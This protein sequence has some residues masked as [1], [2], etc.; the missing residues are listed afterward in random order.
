MA[1]TFVICTVP[2][3][4]INHAQ[5][6]YLKE[7]PIG[8]P[9]I[10]KSLHLRATRLLVS[11]EGCGSEEVSSKDSGRKFLSTFKAEVDRL[12]KNKRGGSYK[13]KA[14][15]WERDNSLVSR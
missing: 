2:K 4:L 11:P 6:K 7:L 5:T 1:L 14:G 8:F 15:T 9:L 13:S 12:L 10:K 3:Y